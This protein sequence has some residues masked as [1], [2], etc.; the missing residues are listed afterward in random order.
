MIITLSG[1]EGSGKSTIV[2]YLRNK[3][4]FLIIPETARILIPLESTVFEDSKDDLSYKS[5][6][7]YLTGSHFIFENDLAKKNSIVFDRN[8]IDSLTYLEM[9]GNQKIELS[10]LQDYID[11]FL[12]DKNKKTLY[13]EVILVKHST[14]KDHI[15]NKIMKDN[16]RK[17]T[18]SP[19]NYIEKAKIWENI[20]L[21]KYNSLKNIGKTL[22][23]INAYP[24]N[25]DVNGTIESVL[26]LSDSKIVNNLK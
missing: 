16:I 9:Y 8:I 25:E 14:N 23:I 18:E 26:K 20:Y 10:K 11:I 17:Y 6:I 22:N 24:D 19:D 13:D 2:N 7:A 12:S 15:L 4:G 1:F 3:Y 5:F 21:E